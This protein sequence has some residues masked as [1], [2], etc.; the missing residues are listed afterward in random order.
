MKVENPADLPMSPQVVQLWQASK[1]G[2]AMSDSPFDM[3]EEEFEDGTETV[4]VDDGEEPQNEEGDNE[5]GGDNE[6]WGELESQLGSVKK[7]LSG[8]EREV[9]RIVI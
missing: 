8:I 9:V 6:E 1:Q 4:G 3:S 7:S 2:G 5:A